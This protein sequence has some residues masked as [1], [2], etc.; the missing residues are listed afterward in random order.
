MWSVCP[1]LGSSPKQG[2]HSMIFST[3]F[4]LDRPAGTRCPAWTHVEPT[5]RG[6]WEAWRWH[7]QTSGNQSCR[8][9]ETEDLELGSKVLVPGAPLCG[10]KWPR[11]GHTYNITFLNCQGGQGFSCIIGDLC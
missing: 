6:R 2:S 5:Q 10:V 4:K 8:G 9:R 1:S 11:D 7:S 3:C